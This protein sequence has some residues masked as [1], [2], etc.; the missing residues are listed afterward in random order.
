MKFPWFRL[1]GLFYVPKNAV[2]WLIL[3]ISIVYAVYSF[4]DIDSRSHSVSDTLMNFVFRL[5]IIGAIYTL[6]AFLT[7]FRRSN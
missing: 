1:Y 3:L 4:I 6:V 5:V 7:S 2:A